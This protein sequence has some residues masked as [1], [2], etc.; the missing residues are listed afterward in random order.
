MITLN[1]RENE[2]INGNNIG[3]IL[4][5]KCLAHAYTHIHSNFYLSQPEFHVIKIQARPVVH[6]L[7]TIFCYFVADSFCIFN[8]RLISDEIENCNEIGV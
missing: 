3:L 8:V 2:Y 4:K 1:E 7:C 5:T 6:A